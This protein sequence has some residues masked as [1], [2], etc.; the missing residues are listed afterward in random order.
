MNVTVEKGRYHSVSIQGD[1]TG[2]YID[3]TISAKQAYE[4]IRALDAHRSEILDMATNYYTC[5]DCG[6][7]HHNSV[8]ICTVN[9]VEDEE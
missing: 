9:N 7:T 1:F 3:L 8:K 6:E 2:P 5:N 4:L